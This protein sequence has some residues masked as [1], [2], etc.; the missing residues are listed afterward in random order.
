MISTRR[1]IQRQIGHRREAE[2]PGPLVGLLE[3][4]QCTGLHPPQ[5]QSGHQLGQDRPNLPGRPAH[6]QSINVRRENRVALRPTGPDHGKARATKEPTVAEAA[7]AVLQI[8][9]GHET[10]EDL[11]VVAAE[12][13]GAHQAPQVVRLHPPV[14]IDPRH[15]PRSPGR[16]GSSAGADPPPA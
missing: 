6:V 16:A 2:H 15:R 13:F 10:I 3:V 8:P 9:F 5:A 14:A 12:R 1:I 7:V 11:S 4:R